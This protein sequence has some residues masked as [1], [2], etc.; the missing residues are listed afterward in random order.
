[1]AGEALVAGPGHLGQRVDLDGMAG[2]DALELAGQVAGDLGWGVVDGP[3][4]AAMPGAG[5]GLA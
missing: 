4:P 5:P 2:P 1:M 3:G